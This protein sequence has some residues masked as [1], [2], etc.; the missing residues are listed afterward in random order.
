MKAQ[1][2]ANLPKFTEDDR[3]DVPGWV[4]EFNRLSR[5]TVHGGEV[6]E[7]DYCTMLVS[8]CDKGTTA[9]DQLRSVQRSDVHKALES[10]RDFEG[11]KFLLLT[12]L[13]TLQ[14]NAYLVKG[15]V[16]EK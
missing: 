5:H 15:D 3:K 9:G 10:K 14:K 7:E 2:P 1:V 8:S 4:E 16:E 12:S 11:C 13:N 6:E